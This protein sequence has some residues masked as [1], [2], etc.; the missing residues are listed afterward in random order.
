MGIAP[1]TELTLIGAVGGG[2]VMR[3]AGGSVSGDAF[4]PTAAAG[5]GAEV[6]LG[7]GW[8]AFAAFRYVVQGIR[9]DNTRRASA[10]PVGELGLAYAF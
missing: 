8:G 10:T 2:P 1:R 7:A 5:V 3:R 4:V 9:I 6:S